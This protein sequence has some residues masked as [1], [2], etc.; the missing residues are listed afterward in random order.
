MA[1]P[2]TPNLS[3]PLIPDGDQAW[4]PAMRGAMTT[5]DGTRKSGAMGRVH[6]LGTTPSMAPGDTQTLDLQFAESCD[7]VAVTA[8]RPCWIRIYSTAAARAAD[9]ARTINIDPTPGTGIMGEVAPYD[10]ALAISWSPAPLF[11]NEDTVLGK[12]AYIAVTNQSTTGTIELDFEILP[13]EYV[14]PGGP[15]GLTGLRG[16]TGDTGATGAAGA[17]GTNGTNGADGR[18]ARTSATW[19]TATLATGAVETQ[20]VALA[21][22]A[23]L[24]K[25]TTTRAARVRIYATAAARAADATRLATVDPALDSGCEL[26]VTTGATLS[27][28]LKEASFANQD[29]TVAA[30]AYLSIT[31]LGT[32]GT[33]GTTLVYSDL[34]A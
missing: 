21:K 23:R 11:N 26:E 20:D 30:T 22:T 4:G 32:S 24:Y 5:L 12:T 16:F 1:Y 29:T 10:G 19:T 6:V 13:Q 33:V 17:N 34:E 27:F 9:A 25:L 8:S 2:V 15:M 18:P 31:N 3:L 7:L 28:I 14:D